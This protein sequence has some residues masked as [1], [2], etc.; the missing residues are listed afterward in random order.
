MNEGEFFLRHIPG[1]RVRRAAYDVMANGVYASMAMG[2]GRIADASPVHLVFDE[3]LLHVT[4]AVV[5]QLA[6]ALLAGHEQQL[7]VAIVDGPCLAC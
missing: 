3:L 7:L 4:V 6:L 5:H 1:M 2:L